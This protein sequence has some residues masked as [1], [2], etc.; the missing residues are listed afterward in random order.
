MLADFDWCFIALKNEKEPIYP[1]QKA[2]K[3]DH[4]SKAIFGTR[5]F[6]L[7]EPEWSTSYSNTPNGYWNYQCLIVFG[8]NAHD[9]DVAVGAKA[10]PER[11]ACIYLT[12]ARAFAAVAS[13]FDIILFWISDYRFTILVSL[14]C[15]KLQETFS[16]FFVL[17]QSLGYW[18]KNTSRLS[19]GWRREGADCIIGD[20]SEAPKIAS[21]FN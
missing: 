15:I 9:V 20:Q 21:Q 17:K 6:W 1:G 14:Q 11:V 4:V 12:L 3:N 13:A 7:H 8:Q 2:R 18:T 16:D 5:N 10:C 19:A